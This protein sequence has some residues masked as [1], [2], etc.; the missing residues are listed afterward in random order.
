MLSGTDIVTATAASVSRCCCL[1]LLLLL[2]LPLDRC[3]MCHPEVPQERGSHSVS[4]LPS[5]PS[6][7]GTERTALLHLSH[8]IDPQKIG[9]PATEVAAAMAAMQ[10]SCQAAF[11][12]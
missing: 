4:A 1:L 5:G 10:T 8:I 9:C 12:F 6:A 2:L 11:I 7:A 3:A